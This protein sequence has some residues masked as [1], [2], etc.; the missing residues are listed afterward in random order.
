LSFILGVAKIYIQEKK[1]YK[2][3]KVFKVFGIIFMVMIIG[4]VLVGCDISISDKVPLVTITGMTASDLESIHA[5]WLFIYDNG[6]D[7]SN[8]N[9]IARVGA[10]ISN[11]DFNDDGIS[12]LIVD[13]M[14]TGSYCLALEL[15]DEILDVSTYYYYTDGKTLEQLGVSET[16]MNKMVKHRI[17]M[18]LDSNTK[19]PF[20][21]F[22]EYD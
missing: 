14:S 18:D 15:R 11:G 9:Y 3:K 21:S 10:D 1:V 2:M 4:F 19:I 5:A 13:D 16:T 20:S 7:I 12:F 17:D 22:V 6:T 8:D